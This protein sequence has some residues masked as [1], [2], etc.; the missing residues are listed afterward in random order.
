MWERWGEEE[1]QGEK[2]EEINKGDD[3]NKKCSF[4]KSKNFKGFLEENRLMGGAQ[5]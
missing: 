3:E 5:S 4:Q 1:K 2:E